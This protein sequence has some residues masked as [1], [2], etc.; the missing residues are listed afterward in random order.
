M[1]GV[2]S[3]RER[4][5]FEWSSHGRLS[6]S[7]RSFIG[8]NVARGLVFSEL[9][10]GGVWGGLGMDALGCWGFEQGFPPSGP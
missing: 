2:F 1:T 10:I 6:G 3:G 9:S 8:K 4:G 5:H 7:H